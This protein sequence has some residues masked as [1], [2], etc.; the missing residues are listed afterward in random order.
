MPWSLISVQRKGVDGRDE[1]GHD[2]DKIV[3]KRLES[4]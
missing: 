1:P 4:A 3:F 2:D